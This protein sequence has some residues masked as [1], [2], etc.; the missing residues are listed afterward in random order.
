[1][2]GSAIIFD[3]DGTLLDTLEDI[4]D[5]FNNA[6]QKQGFP[7]FPVAHYRYLVG[8]GVRT[9]AQRA[10]SKE[11]TTTEIIDRC[12]ED[13]RFFYSH[14]QNEKTRPYPGI[15]LLLDALVKNNIPMAVLSN[16]PHAETI[17]CIKQ[18]LPGCQFYHLQ[19]HEPRFP[20]KPDPTAALHIAKMLTVDPKR[21]MFWGDTG[22]DMRTATA[23]GMIPVGV[24]WGFR[25]RQELVEAGATILLEK[26]EDIFRYCRDT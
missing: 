11:V 23:A 13:Y 3:L 26:P 18:Y 16:K 6:L 10:L 19:G 14:N 25:N 24:L 9:L 21:I 7:A 12:I 5:S 17:R 1:M 4:A 2:I 8:E 15:P 20:L 22:T